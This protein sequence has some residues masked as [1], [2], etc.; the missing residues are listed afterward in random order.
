MG[1]VFDEYGVTEGGRDIDPY[2]IHPGDNQTALPSD[3]GS[4]HT[5]WED[6]Y[7]YCDKCGAFDIYSRTPTQEEYY[8]LEPYLRT[9]PVSSTYDG[10]RRGGSGCYVAIVLG[11]LDVIFCFV[12]F[13]FL[14]NPL[15]ILMYMTIGVVFVPIY[16]LAVWINQAAE[17]PY[18]KWEKD[19]KEDSNKRAAARGN[20]HSQ[21]IK[22][23][24]EYNEC[25]K[26]GYRGSK[27][28]R[29]YNPLKLTLKDVPREQLNLHPEH[30][31]LF[32]NMHPELR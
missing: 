6:S 15:N 31:D 24:K 5:Y 22:M 27:F 17:R 26:C 1:V 32:L 10:P 7:L 21:L 13:N 18:K 25:R 12:K 2:D 8:A 28:D 29:S 4:Y 30:G 19:F 23:G 3:P 11:L 9:E 14:D 20:A 16:F